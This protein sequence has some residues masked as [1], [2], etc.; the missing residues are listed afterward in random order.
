MHWAA[1]VEVGGVHI[2]A[3]CAFESLTLHFATLSG[4]SVFFS[5]G[6]IF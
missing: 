1:F 5:H 6:D 4:L 3:A 2:L